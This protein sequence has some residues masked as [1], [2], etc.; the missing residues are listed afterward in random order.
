ML[1]SSQRYIFFCFTVLLTAY[2]ALSMAG[3]DDEI[4]VYTDQINGEGNYGWEMHQNWV[5]IGTKKPE[6][7][8]DSAAQGQFRHTSEFSYGINDHWELGAYFPVLIKNGNVTVEGGRAR[9]KFLDHLNSEVFYGLNVEYG[10]ARKRSEQN[11][12]GAELRPIIGYRD[13]D[14]LIG[15]NPVV[16]LATSGN[17]AW[18]PT[19]EP[20]VK[21][22]HSIGNGI[23]L[24]VE[25]YA[26]FG[27]F[28][29]IDPWHQQSQ[30]SYLTLDTIKFN[31]N[32]NLGIGHG[33]TGASND[34]TFKLILGLPINGW[35]ETLIGL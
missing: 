11:H 27:A 29:R 25:H 20:Q 30:T 24:G 34:L 3:G 18:Q 32:I 5:P 9:I 13:D 21:L 28:S 31:T 10:Y 19:F 8:G 33:W 1:N 23:M 14:W 35:A 22:A 7:P 15:F 17:G 26:G 2:S 12:W 16:G 4:Q 6:Y